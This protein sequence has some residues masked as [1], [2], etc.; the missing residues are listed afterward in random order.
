[1]VLCDAAALFRNAGSCC[2]CGIYSRLKFKN[3]TNSNSKVKKLIKK[4]NLLIKNQTR[5]NSLQRELEFNGPEVK[6][7]R[8]IFLRRTKGQY[9][10]IAVISS[11]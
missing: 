4:L 8:H 6:G 11:E 7:Q 2:V 1:M 9:P 5:H 3:I 10:P